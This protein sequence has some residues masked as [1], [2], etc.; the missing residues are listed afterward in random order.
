VVSIIV[1]TGLT[2]FYT[3][4][5]G[6]TAVI[7]T[8]VVQM[9]LYVV[10][11][12]VSLF[13]ILQHIPGGWEYVVA[14]AGEAG[15]FQVF[16][17]QFEW[18]RN[19]FAQTYTFWAGLIGGCFLTTASHGTEQMMVQRLLAA[20]NQGESRLALMASW[21]VIFT[22]FSLFLVVGIILYVFHLDT[23]IPAPEPLDRLYPAFVWSYLKPGA[24]ALVIAAILAASMANISSAL[25]SLASTSV[26]DFLKP[27]DERRGVQ[28]ADSS[29]LRLSRLVTI[30]WGVILMAIGIMARQWGS[31]LEAG[32]AIASIPFGALLGVFL[33]GVLT[34]SVQ[35]RAA[36]GG[37]IA[38]LTT[39][40]YVKF[41]TTIAWTWYVFIGA[42]VTFSVGCLLAL[43]FREIREERA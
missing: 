16:D 40:V 6:M 39:M 18:S 30:F 12:V 23:G 22:L 36:L 17:F 11:A 1:I 27:L 15:K 13:V 38:G 24:A 3:F 32:L 25:N 37:I 19:F 29:Y 42:T 20:R 5:G 31:V 10:G 4:E 9:V 8:D 7:W 26:M 35:E 28:R 14:T 43:L 2:L 21:I 41:L 34:K 33:L